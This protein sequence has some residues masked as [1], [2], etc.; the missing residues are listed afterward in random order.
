VYL[1]KRLGALLSIIVLIPAITAVV[2]FVPLFGSEPK[3][4]KSNDGE[5]DTVLLAK[6]SPRAV[7]G[8]VE[9]AARPE[10]ARPEQIG[11]ENADADEPDTDETSKSDRA[12]GGDTLN[13]LVLG[14]DKRPDGTFVEGEGSRADTIMVA[15][16]WPKSGQIRLLSVPRDLF[17]E[18]EPSV[19]DRINAAYAYGGVPGIVEVLEGQWD[20]SVDHHAVVDFEGF[21]EIIDALGGVTLDVGSELPPS[22]RLGEGVQTLDGRHALLYARNR[23]TPGGDLDRIARQQ[24]VVAA[25]R[26][27]ALGWG[28][29][30]RLHKIVPAIDDAI[31]TDVSTTEAISLAQLLAKNKDSMTS[32]QLKGAPM[33][34]PDGRQVLLP[35]EEKNQL[36]L[37][38][39]NNQ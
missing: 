1:W 20:I 13:M 28:T 32:A 25:L 15:R 39:F 22:W 26:G 5:P 33:A 9:K 29:L 19:H 7:G 6:D 3:L 10:K 4:G 34:L 12:A 2:A 27:Q 8:E 24:K 30:A 35:E 23:N 36:I 16:V 14:I 38:E 18:I 31:E 37:Q 21:E 11:A 17:V